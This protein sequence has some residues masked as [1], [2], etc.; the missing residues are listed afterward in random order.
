MAIAQRLVRRVHPSARHQVPMDEIT[1]DFIK[2]EF[3][4]LTPEEITNLHVPDTMYEIRPSSEAPSGTRGRIAAFE[5]F[6]VDKD[7][8][9]I[10]LKDPT[11][12]ELY[13]IT[14]AKG[15]LT[16]REDALMKALHGEVP[17]QEVFGL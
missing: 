11:E 13:K 7:V 4:D 5:M 15:M 12:P 2:K 6:A 3:A 8:Q 10:I 1:K 14:R 17:M 9:Q 16:M